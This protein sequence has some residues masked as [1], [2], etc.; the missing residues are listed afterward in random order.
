MKCMF[1]D[2]ETTGLNPKKDRIVEI[3]II[4]EME[5]KEKKVFH[6]FIKHEEY[7]KGYEKAFKINGLT[8]EYLEKNGDNEIQ[9][10]NELIAFLDNEISKYDKEDKCIIAGYCVGFDD[11]FLRALFD[12]YSNRYYGSYFMSCLLDVRS[13]VAEYV[14]RKNVKFVNYKL[15][16]VCKIFGIEIE[17]HKAMSD[18]KATYDLY[19]KIRGGKK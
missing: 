10:Y 6:R 16:T 1:L 15:G 9:V 11:G 18:I 17:T 4:F 3:A 12:M 13:T 7:P 2:V 19:Y 14:K 8:K 5:N